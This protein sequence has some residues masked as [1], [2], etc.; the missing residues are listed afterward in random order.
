MYKF[1][2]WYYGRDGVKAFKY[3]TF[4]SVKRGLG[5]GAGL[6]SFGKGMDGRYFDF[7]EDIISQMKV[8]MDKYIREQIA[9]RYKLHLTLMGKKVSGK[10][11]IPKFYADMKRRFHEC[12]GS[13]Y[14]LGHIISDVEFM[15]VV[16]DLFDK[17][18]VD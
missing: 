8:N 11:C 13:E 18:G 12:D 5:A 10:S 2:L 6:F 3:R 15:E 1:L 9:P 7:Y 17:Y 16:H 4:T 14:A